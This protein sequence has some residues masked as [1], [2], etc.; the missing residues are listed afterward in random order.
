MFQSLFAVII[1]YFYQ[2]NAFYFNPDVFAILIC[3]YGVFV[4]FKDKS[5]WL[6]EVA[7]PLSLAVSH[8]FM[9]VTRGTSYIFQSLGS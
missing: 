9:E 1:C 7:C 4:W 6:V 8:K 5:V 3:G 2:F